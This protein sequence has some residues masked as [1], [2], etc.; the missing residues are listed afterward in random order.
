M[1]IH[2]I[3]EY[4]KFYYNLFLSESDYIFFDKI[5]FFIYGFQYNKRNDFTIDTLIY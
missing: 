4:L 5:V 2:L 1:T 3:M